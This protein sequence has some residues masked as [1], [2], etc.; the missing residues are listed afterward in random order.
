[1]RSRY[2]SIDPQ[3]GI[4]ISGYNVAITGILF[5]AR[6]GIAQGESGRQPR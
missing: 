4:S 3:L 1:M 2:K 6:A 5:L